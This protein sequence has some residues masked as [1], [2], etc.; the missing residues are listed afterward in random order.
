[1]LFLRLFFGK[2]F[3]KGSFFN[4]NLHFLTYYGI[5]IS[6]NKLKEVFFMHKIDATAMFVGACLP[7]GLFKPGDKYHAFAFRDSPNGVYLYLEDEGGHFIGA[8]PSWQFVMDASET[9]A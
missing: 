3:S 7:H 8:H 4:L 5:I 1:M 9:T 6:T 2:Y